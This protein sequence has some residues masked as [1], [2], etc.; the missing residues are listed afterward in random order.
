MNVGDLV[1]YVYHLPNEQP[2]VGLVMRIGSAVIGGYAER[3]VAVLWNGHQSHRWVR[4]ADLK[5]MK[6]ESR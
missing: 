1:T 6:N 2:Y 3:Q 4:V 5:V